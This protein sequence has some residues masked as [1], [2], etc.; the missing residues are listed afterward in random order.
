ME[1]QEEIEKVMKSKNEEME[2]QDMK[3]RDEEKNKWSK[4]LDKKDKVIVDLSQQLQNLQES[5]E[6]LKNNLTLEYEAQLQQ[7]H[8]QLSERNCQLQTLQKD[9]AKLQH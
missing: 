9:L 5:T 8:S 1:L 3:A 7:Q 4:E 6:T 2:E